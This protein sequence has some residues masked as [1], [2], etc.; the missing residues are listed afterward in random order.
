MY[1]KSP[2]YGVHGEASGLTDMAI[3]VI[4]KTSSAQGTGVY[5]VA[6]GPSGF[7]FAGR[8]VNSSADGIGA[9]G[10]SIATTGAACGV[11]G[12][13]ASTTG[14]GVRGSVV[15]TSGVSYGGYFESESTS[16]RACYGWATATS[17]E[18]YGGVFKTDSPDGYG[19]WARASAPTG[20][21]HAGH[22][23]SVSP[24][25]RG[26]WAKASATTGENIAGYFETSSQNGRGVVG[27]APA[28][29]GSAWGV[30]G[31]SSGSAGVGV[32]GAAWATSGESYGGSFYT[33]ST[34]GAGISGSATA[35][36][37]TACGGSFSSDSPDG[38]GLSAES[39]LMGVYG[40]AT[41]TENDAWGIGVK[42]ESYSENGR[43]VLGTA[44][45]DNGC[46]VFGEGG[47]CGG[48]FRRPV[49]DYWAHVASST[50]KILGTGTVSFV[51]NHPV[52]SDLVIMYAAPEGDEVATYT[53][54]TA[55]IKNGIARIPLGETFKWVT[56][57]DIGLT[58]HLTPKGTA[59]LLYVEDLTT[60]EMVVRS[61]EG[62]PDDVV[63]DYIV[64]G[65]RIGFEEIGIVKER[66][67]RAGLPSLEQ[68]FEM[69]ARHPDLRSYNALERFRRMNSTIGFDV[70]DLSNASRLHDAIQR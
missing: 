15:A 20:S 68:E 36:T 29:N 69:Y 2:Q 33:R 54:G 56:N 25:G 52:R 27:I 12:L 26:V 50:H 19:V 61:A 28:A 57:P 51:Q 5:G 21:S 17:G 41:T 10:W 23:E 31:R 62:F 16:G 37:G 4:G 66:E 39:P 1:G 30:Y 32:K 45:G 63:V 11:E 70:S 7:S 49:G 9:A 53:R 22:F 24:E 18:T 6:A 43:G 64:Y 35:T 55:R 67:E 47:W 38:M 48:Y 13:S 46:G 65:L 40:E 58:A 34:S 8:F 59:T 44:L 60:D 3:G 42:G 14:T